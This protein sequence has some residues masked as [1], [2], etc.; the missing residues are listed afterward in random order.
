MLR[1]IRRLIG[2][3]VEPRPDTTFVTVVYETRDKYAGM[4][5]AEI[6]YHRNNHVGR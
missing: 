2:L 3:P 5:E 1:L 6:A 4:T